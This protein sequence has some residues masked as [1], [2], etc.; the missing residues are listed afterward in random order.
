MTRLLVAGEIDAATAPRLRDAAAIALNQRGGNLH[1]NLAGVTFMDS[2]GIH[3]LV[4]TKRRAD[5]L[6]GRLE[7]EDVPP[8]IARLLALMGLSGR[9]GTDRPRNVALPQYEIQ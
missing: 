2:A 8:R 3:V 5:A 6:A 7:L 1:I 9:F 4:A